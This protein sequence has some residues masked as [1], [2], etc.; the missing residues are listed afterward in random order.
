MADITAIVLTLNEEEYLTD[1]LE[2]IKDLVSRIV[3]ID[4][5]ST[6][7]T[8]NIA[9]KY[10]AEVYTN[11][12]KNYSTQYQYG[13]NVAK[14]TTKW[15]LRIDADERI[16]EK[17]RDEILRELENNKNSEITGYE[18]RYKNRFLGKFLKH[19]GFYPWYKL[20]L[21]QTNKGSIEQR[22]MDEH[23]ILSSGKSKRLKED[24]IH[25]SFRNLS[26]FTTKCNW[27]SSREA[28]DYFE[29]KTNTCKLNKRTWIKMKIYYRLPIGFRSWL[30]YFYC[31]YIK[32]GFL[33]GKEGKIY[34]FLHSYW[35]RFLVDSKIFEHK[36][37]GTKIRKYG[38]INESGKE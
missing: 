32:L 27:Y 19:G 15:I 28:A 29:R 24:C 21:Y 25:E 12:F 16:S 20:A 31:Y 30:F 18:I 11:P 23:I 38:S 7:Q 17:G 22:N 8:V 26:F 35:Y 14:V 2:S 9:K 10:G 1:C 6:D 13:V 4:S 3:V 33:D 34:A 37:L 36:K 5:G